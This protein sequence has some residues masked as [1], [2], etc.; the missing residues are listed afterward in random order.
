MTYLKK[1]TLK[2]R[3]CNSTPFPHLVFSTRS[4]NMQMSPA[5]THW[6]T[7]TRWSDW[8]RGRLWRQKHQRFQAVFLS[9]WFTAV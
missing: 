4:M 3:E 6:F 9:L 5:P 2:Y 1:N 7:V 8:L